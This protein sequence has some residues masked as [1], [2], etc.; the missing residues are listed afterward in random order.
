MHLP[1]GPLASY[2]PTRMTDR[3]ATFAKRQRELEQ[4]QRATQRLQ[5][6][7]ERKASASANPA[8]P[9]A[10]PDIDPDLIGIVAGPQPR[11]DD[12][13]PAEV[14]DLGTS[15]VPSDDSP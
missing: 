10:D 2:T 14:T 4:K 3:K 11:P 15:L 7:A 6:K 13:A 9:N 5:R 1:S 8:D 12:D